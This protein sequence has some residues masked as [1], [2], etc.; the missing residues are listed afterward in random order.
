MKG[1][2]TFS[3]LLKQI[4]SLREKQYA[5]LLTGKPKN[6]WVA[7]VNSNEVS[8]V[9][10]SKPHGLLSQGWDGAHKV[11]LLDSENLEN[12]TNT[13]RKWLIRRAKKSAE[14]LVL[15]LNAKF[16]LGLPVKED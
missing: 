3:S 7:H 9:H 16:P 6:S 8:C 5:K 2:P 1:N 10:T 15:E 14:E 12:Y 13:V 11:I 4:H